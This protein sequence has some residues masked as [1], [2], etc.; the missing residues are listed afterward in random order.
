[1]IFIS[2]PVRGQIY[3]AETSRKGA[4]RLLWSVMPQKDGPDVRI[5]PTQV[6]IAV[7]RQA[8][9]KQ[10]KLRNLDSSPPTPKGES[11]PHE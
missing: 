10:Y 5:D 7:R 6:P 8:Y 11:L 9:R 1:M 3:I 4:R 2:E